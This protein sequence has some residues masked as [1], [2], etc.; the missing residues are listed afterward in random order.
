MKAELLLCMEEPCP[1]I[2]SPESCSGPSGR[3][4]ALVST[5]GGCPLPSPLV[6]GKQKGQ[7]R[8]TSSAP[9]GRLKHGFVLHYFEAKLPAAEEDEAI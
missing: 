1:V 2:G 3:D 7:S 5:Y 8:G 9:S 4:P 6:L